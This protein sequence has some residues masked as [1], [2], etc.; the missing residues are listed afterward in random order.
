MKLSKETNMDTKESVNAAD[1]VSKNAKKLKGSKTKTNEPANIK[2]SKISALYSAKQSDI[3]GAFCL[4]LVAVLALLYFAAFN[5]A[6]SSLKTN[7]Q[8]IATANSN[9]EK[10]K[11]DISTNEKKEELIKKSQDTI[12]SFNKMFPKDADQVRLIS[13]VRKVAAEA[14]VVLSDFQ[15]QTPETLAEDNA[16]ADT[17]PIGIEKMTLSIQDIDIVKLEKFISGVENMERGIS[18]GSISYTTGRAT[19]ILNCYIGK[20]IKNGN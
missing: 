13:S 17:Y 2:L 9:I 11:N 1:K 16:N 6:I 3:I 14:G 20:E 8:K 18:V 7:T 12:N 15:F 19:V 10:Y 5:P 4:I